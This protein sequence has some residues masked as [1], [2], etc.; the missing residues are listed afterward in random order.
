MLGVLL[1]VWASPIEGQGLIYLPQIPR[2]KSE[3]VLYITK[4]ISSLL[5]TVRE[6]ALAALAMVQMHPERREEKARL[7]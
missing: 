7:N 6:L 3:E 4:N 5:E 2:T 1:E